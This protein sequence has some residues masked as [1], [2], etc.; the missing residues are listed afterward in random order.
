MP[1]R[2]AGQIATVLVAFAV[3][4]DS[5]SQISVGKD[6]K[7]PPPATALI[8]PAVKPAPK[9][10]AECAPFMMEGSRRRIRGP[11]SANR[12]EC[13][14]RAYLSGRSVRARTYRHP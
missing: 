6:T 9:D 3:T 1:P 7:V 5:P 4:G 12:G 8:I 11:P 10:R 2:V 14:A 13:R